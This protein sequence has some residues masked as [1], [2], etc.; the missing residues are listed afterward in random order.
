MGPCLSLVRRCA[1]LSCGV[2]ASLAVCTASPLRLRALADVSH[3]LRHASLSSAAGSESRMRLRQALG[4]YWHTEG[5][6]VVTEHHTTVR[7]AGVN[8]SGLETTVGA[9]GGLDRQDYHTIL[10]TVANAGYNTIRVP[11]SNEMVEH[12]SVPSGI[13]FE[14]S[15]GAIN[16]DLEGLTSLQILDHIVFA[17]GQLGLRVVLDNH[18]SESGSGAENNGLWF[19]ERYPERAWIA[20]WVSLA[21]RYRGNTTVIGFD[22]RNEPH[23]ASSGGACWDCGGARDWHLA[24]ERAGNSILRANPN[25]LIFVE[26][27]D[28]VDGRGDFWGGNLS[29]VRRS[30][31][32]LAIP[33]RLVYSPH[34]YG[35]AEYRQSWFNAETTP[36]SLMAN[37]RYNWGF[38]NESDLAPVWVGEFGT[39]NDDASVVSD[40][41][42]SEGQYFAT[43]IS[44]LGSHP[45]VG[46]SYWGLNAEDRYGLLDSS[47][48]APAN[49]QK[50]MALARIGPMPDVYASTP[51]TAA[52][53]AVAA[54][55]A[56]TELVPARARVST[57]RRPLSSSGA[58]AEPA[59]TPVVYGPPAL[60]S[61]PAAAADRP[62]AKARQRPA[63]SRATRAHPRSASALLDEQVRLATEQALRD[64]PPE[65]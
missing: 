34:V 17:A 25:L 21:A 19:T 1:V 35:P 47:Y 57:A 49:Q 62:A 18:R 16:S 7:L 40:A 27:T 36:A 22:L 46:W 30:P 33:D 23:N 20:D 64:L 55:A 39:L 51:R 12:P 59:A 60:Q 13:R 31:V 61:D 42:G 5:N 28:T 32:R 52:P 48:T 14:N 44:Y 11:F 53:A 41:P 24:A 2:L 45:E 4:G 29:G 6:R 43:L 8:W 50:L 37:W 10:R 56:Q 9:P 3:N 65:D 54:P 26:G 15:T 63:Q 38:I 58:A